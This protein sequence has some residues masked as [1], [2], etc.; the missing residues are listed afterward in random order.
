MPELLD[1]AILFGLVA[2]G[3]CWVLKRDGQRRFPFWMVIAIGVIAAYIGPPAFAVIQSV[4]SSVPVLSQ[5]TEGSVLF[6][7]WVA[8][9]SL[10]LFETKG[11]P[12]RVPIWVGLSIAVVASIAV[13][14]FMDKVTGTYQDM[15]LKSNINNCTKGMLGLVSPRQFTNIC[16]YP[17]T[18]GLCLPTEENPAPCRQSATIAPG[19]VAN[20]DPGEARLASLPSNPN[21]L[22][23]VA[24]RPP[25]RP[26][27]S[28]SAIG[29]G[30]TGVC[31]PGL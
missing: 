13:P 31:L 11:Q 5:L 7:L 22:T 23:V 1:G 19:A 24:C 27:R 4:L 14:Q 10:T 20:F 17:I 2:G 8:L 18:V 6:G 30:Y 15:S 28:L 12:R 16:D 29:R 26:S 25:L 9:G 21:G 3:F